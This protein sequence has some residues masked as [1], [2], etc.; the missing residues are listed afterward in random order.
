MLQGQGTGFSASYL[1]CSIAS[2]HAFSSFVN[3]GDANGLFAYN[4]Q[5]EVSATSNYEINTRDANAASLSSKLCVSANKSG[6]V[7]YSTGFSALPLAVY[8]TSVQEYTFQS[9]QVFGVQNTAP[10]TSGKGSISI[11][12]MAINF[13]GANQGLVPTVYSTFA[14]GNYLVVRRVSGS[15]YLS[16]YIYNAYDTVQWNAAL[17][18]G[19]DPSNPDITQ[20]SAWSEYTE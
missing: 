14:N 2:G 9:L 20:A 5:I 19:W 8:S 3:N 6:G 17:Y 12:F 13:P 1:A 18:V 7:N 11:D 16:S 15:Y 10:A 4:T